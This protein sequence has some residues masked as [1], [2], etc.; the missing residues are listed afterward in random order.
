M[1]QRICETDWELDNW[2]I[3]KCCCQWGLIIEQQIPSRFGTLPCFTPWVFIINLED[4]AKGPLAEG[5]DAHLWWQGGWKSSHTR[6]W[7]LLGRPGSLAMHSCSPGGRKRGGCSLSAGLAASVAEL[8]KEG[9]RSLW[10]S[11][12]VQTPLLANGG[13]GCLG[14][15]TQGKW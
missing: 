10:M 6:V 13:K 11:G 3:S 9:W 5:I 15:S 12:S 1:N 14:L 2:Q 8:L 4:N 7:W